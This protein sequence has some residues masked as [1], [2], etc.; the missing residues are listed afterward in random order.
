MAAP[1]PPPACAHCAAPSPPSQCGGCHAV[2]YCGVPCQRA[3]WPAHKPLCRA[4]QAALTGALETHCSGCAVALTKEQMGLQQCTACSWASY[5]GVACQRAHWPTHKVVCKAVGKA[6]LAREI[7]DATAGDVG[8]MFNVALYYE[9]GPGTAKD[10]RAAFEWYRRAAEVGDAAAQFNLGTCYAL[11]KGVTADVSAAFEWNR[12]AAEAGDAEAQS[13]LGRCYEDG[14]G[15]A[16]D[17]SEAVAWYRRAA[18]RGFA[19]AQLNLGRCYVLGVGVAVDARAAAE[20][21]ERAAASG[22]ATASE[23]ARA[24]LALLRALHPP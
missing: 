16:A 6:K 3:A 18:D 5:C 15:V 8:A 24:T 10:L 12:R 19:G 2:T 7:A 21:L 17:A 4:L 1:P 9:R 22:D 13:N 23:R 20:W 11:G 14:E